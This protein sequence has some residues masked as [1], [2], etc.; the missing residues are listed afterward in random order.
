MTG[1]S[2]VN[3]NVLAMKQHSQLNRSVD[4]QSTS[5]ERLSSGLK[6]NTAKDDAAGLQISNRLQSQSRGMDVAIRNANDGISMLQTAE[7]ALGE[8]TENLMRMRDLTLRYANDS[9]ISEDR[10]AIREE[11]ESLK[12]ELTRI[13][14]TTSFSGDKLLNGTNSFRSFQV[15]ANSGESIRIELPRMDNITE[16]KKQSDTVLLNY[17]TLNPSFTND[18][19]RSQPGQY[20]SFYIR[21]G[22]KWGEPMTIT[23]PPGTSFRDLVDD[24]NSQFGDKM[25]AYIEEVEVVS[26]YN[27]DAKHI[28]EYLYYYALDG[29]SIGCTNGGVHVPANARN[30]IFGV[31]SVSG[32]RYMDLE[33]SNQIIPELTDTTDT[34]E[35]IKQLDFAIKYTDSQRAYLGATQNRLSH[36]INNLSQTS[37]NVAASNGQIKDTDFAKES[38]ELTKLS[39]LR[40]ANTSML[41]QAGNAPRSAL[42]LLS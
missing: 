9:L 13:T 35:L 33:S 31:T 28:R 12:D 14:N 39:I 20:L 32:R 19:W 8:Y 37:E 23:P 41:A 34:D 26:K 18:R 11:F 16:E 30:N 15:G 4:K 24:F 2:S 21:E 7:G 1:I 38:T 22:D 40:E 3:T 42:N 6:I 10:E 25:K 17:N 36:A 29:S 27:P 5:M